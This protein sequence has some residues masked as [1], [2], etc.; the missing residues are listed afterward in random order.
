MAIRELTTFNAEQFADLKELIRQLN[1]ELEMTEETLRACV[2]DANSHLYVLEN[3]TSHILG[4]AMLCIF[5]Q[6]FNTVGS[7]ESVVV[8]S[9]CRGEGFGKLLMDHV[10]TQ[11]RAM[12]PIELH[13][14]SSPFRTAANA[15]Y[16]SCGF[17]P[18]STN[19]YHL[20]LK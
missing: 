18:Y 15:L 3:E 6:P 16:L 20:A 2:E 4:C 12:A 13:L 8:H 19:C 17:Q 14:T 9:D 10:L 1:P 5:H 11:A 7:I